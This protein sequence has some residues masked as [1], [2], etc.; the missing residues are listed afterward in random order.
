[1]ETECV[2]FDIDG[3]I[4]DNN[5]RLHYLTGPDKNWNLYNSEM[6]KDKAI[7][8]VLSKLKTLAKTKPI[9]LLTG[10]PESKRNTTVK[11]LRDQGVGFLFANRLADLTKGYIYL[12]MRPDDNR[13]ENHHYKSKEVEKIKRAGLKPVIAYDDDIKCRRMFRDF[14]IRVIDPAILAKE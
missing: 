1:M 11:W 7:T 6:H 9:I 4:A 12:I 13:D 14:G 10:R 3:T 2:I 5:H 8:A